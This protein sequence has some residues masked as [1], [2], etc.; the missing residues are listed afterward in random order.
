MRADLAIL[1]F[2]PARNYAQMRDFIPF[3]L[4]WQNVG[5][6][7]SKPSHC[8]SP[9]EKSNLLIMSSTNAT[10]LMLLWFKR[11]LILLL[12]MGLIAGVRAVAP[13]FLA[14]SEPVKHLTHT[15]ARGSLSVTVTP[16]IVPFRKSNRPKS[17]C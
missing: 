15:V 4:E 11:S 9:P 10:S 17:P 2:E 16:T 12:A 14:P 1:S 3:G 8:R 13:R 7:T 5:F 6:T